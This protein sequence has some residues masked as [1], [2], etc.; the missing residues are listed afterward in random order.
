MTFTICNQTCLAAELNDTVTPP[1]ESAKYIR[2]HLFLDR[3][4]N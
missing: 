3:T 4:L 2:I 1:K